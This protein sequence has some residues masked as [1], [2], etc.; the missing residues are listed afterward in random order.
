MARE[1]ALCYIYLPGSRRLRGSRLQKGGN[2]KGCSPNPNILGFRLWTPQTDSWWE[3]PAQAWMQTVARGR[4]QSEDTEQEAGR[5]AQGWDALLSQRISWIHRGKN[6]SRAV[7]NLFSWQE[8]CKHLIAESNNHESWHYTHHFLKSLQW[9][10]NF[11]IIMPI[12]WVRYLR[13]SAT[14]C[15]ICCGAGCESL[16]SSAPQVMRS[17][18]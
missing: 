16:C 5:L 9:S 8:A 14:K 1:L 4:W 13:L 12:L 17:W 18:D 6:L 11:L 15:L 3:L 7:S 10:T 2:S